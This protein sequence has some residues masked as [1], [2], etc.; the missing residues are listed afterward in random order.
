LEVALKAYENGERYNLL[1]RR[2]R[3]IEDE[4]S[5][6]GIEL[7]SDNHYPMIFTWKEVKFPYL[8]EDA[9]MSGFDLH[10][11]S[12]YL[13]VKNLLQ[14]SCIQPDFEDAW[15]KFMNWLGNYRRYHD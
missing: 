9:R 4:V 6:H 11:K 13:I 3:F 15:V 7:L 10:Y 12:D 1:H 14:V 5:K 8:A 2:M